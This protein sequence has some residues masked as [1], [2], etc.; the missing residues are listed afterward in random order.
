[1]LTTGLK[2]L[3][4]VM[5][6]YNEAACIESVTTSWYTALNDL[7]IDFEM[8]VLNDG[9]SDGTQECLENISMLPRIRIINKTNS[10]HGPTILEGYQLAVSSSEW[11]FQVDSD[12]EMS[13]AFFQ[14]LWDKRTC[15]EALF[16]IR[17]DR[18]QGIG[19]KL[20]SGFS[21]LTIR[22]LYG[23]GIRDVN[24]PYRLMHAPILARIIEQIPAGTF[25]PNIII[26]GALIAAEVPVYNHPIPHSERK[27]GTVSIVKWRLWKAAFISFWQTLWCR[28]R[29]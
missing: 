2:E 16:G 6:V 8:I 19:R 9:S 18:I 27:T 5:P 13:P 29:I 15:Y 25:A 14:A 11:V 28:P 3:T 21:R 10:G 12:D 7:K 22:L 20:I 24:V 26:S 17:T 1:M 4:L 23:Q